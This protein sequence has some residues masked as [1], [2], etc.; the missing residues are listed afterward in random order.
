MVDKLMSTKTLDGMMAEGQDV[1]EVRVPL[2]FMRKCTL[3]IT[4]N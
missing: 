4:T 2:R 3:R 1:A